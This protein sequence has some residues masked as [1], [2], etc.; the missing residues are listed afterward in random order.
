MM[1]GIL[2]IISILFSIEVS[3][4]RFVT[5]TAMTDQLLE[6][7]FKNDGVILINPYKCNCLPARDEIVQPIDTSYA[8]E[9]FITYTYT[10]PTTIYVLVYNKMKKVYTTIYYYSD[11]L[12]LKTG[13]KPPKEYPIL[14]RIK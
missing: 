7:E 6:W 10:C 5:E 1:K 11:K 13:S 4:Q 3:A 9:H 14:Y 2:L 8:G 12:T